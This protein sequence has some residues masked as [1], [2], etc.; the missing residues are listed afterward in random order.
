MKALFN[1]MRPA[2]IEAFNEALAAVDA[3]NDD[4]DD[5]ATVAADLDILEKS[6]NVDAVIIEDDGLRERRHEV[7]SYA[8]ATAALTVFTAMRRRGAW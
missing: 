7:E 5:A 1:V 4:T 3:I 6:L 8:L 2:E